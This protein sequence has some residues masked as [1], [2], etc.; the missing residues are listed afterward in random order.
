MKR[1]LIVTLLLAFGA[2]SAQAQRNVTWVGG[3]G[4]DS[5]FWAEYA[6]QFQTARNIASS[7]LDYAT[8]GP[9][10]A[11]ARQIPNRGANAI[12]IGHS[13]GGVA[14]REI[15]QLEP[16]RRVGGIITMGSPMN[17]ARI[18]RAGLRGEVNGYIDHG[19][20][21]VSKGPLRQSLGLG[22]II[23]QASVIG[24]ALSGRGIIELLRTAVFDIFDIS[25]FDSDA[26]E[27]LAEGSQYIGQAIAYRPNVPRI[28]IN[29]TES[30]PVH[31]RLASSALGDDNDDDD[32]ANLSNI[33]RGVY[34]V[35]YIRNLATAFIPLNAWRAAGWK[36][37]R[38][39]FDNE[40]E[41]GWNN[42]IGATRS[43]SRRSCYEVFV[44]SDYSCYD[45]IVTYEDYLAC[46][47]LC[48]QEQCRT[49]TTRYN[50]P[51]DGLFHESTQLGQSTAAVR[52]NWNPNATFQ[53]I[54]AN[55]MEYDE[56]PGT[57]ENLNIIFDR[58]DTR[59]PLFFRTP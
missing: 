25:P 57:R 46:Q 52:S 28:S 11:T 36:A 42:L 14:L 17:G 47:D 21:E 38:D 49:I 29:G 24:R 33:A 44:C 6:Q 48:Y 4:D 53:S 39:Y 45:N 32:F 5:E 56:H 1:F 9:V 10:Q 15:D 50:Q 43:E 26:E 37:G 30:S 23:I 58:R 40:S 8:A 34:N 3:L 19:V 35:Q 59:V 7:N 41:K 2:L 13:L 51:S 16:S 55:H 54:G 31:F 12:G 20:N 22:F 18:V 27:D